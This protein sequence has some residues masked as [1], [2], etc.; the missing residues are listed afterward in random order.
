MEVDASEQYFHFPIVY[1]SPKNAQLL[2]TNLLIK[3]MTVPGHI[4]LERLP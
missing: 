4:K 1:E 2:L 3:D